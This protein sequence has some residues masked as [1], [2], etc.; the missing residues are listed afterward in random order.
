VPWRLIGQHVDARRRVAARQADQHQPPGAHERTELPAQQAS[1]PSRPTQQGGNRVEHHQGPDPGELRDRG[2]E[3][4]DRTAPTAGG[5]LDR[6]QRSTS[7]HL[8]GMYSGYNPNGDSADRL[9]I[10]PCLTPPAATATPGAF[11]AGARLAPATPRLIT[12]DPR[13]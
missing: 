5:F 8:H 9:V 1:R 13:D 11:S 2:G 12:T 7:S 4:R 6:P 3:L 10:E